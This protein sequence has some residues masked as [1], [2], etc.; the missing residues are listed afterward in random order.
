MAERADAFDNI[1]IALSHTHY[2]GDHHF[3]TTLTFNLMSAHLQY[4]RRLS[5]VTSSHTLRDTQIVGM[6]V[7]EPLSP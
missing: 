7:L 3:R 6:C 1:F 5:M 4:P 2:A